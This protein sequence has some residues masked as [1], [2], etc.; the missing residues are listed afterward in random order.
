MVRQQ[1][2]NDKRQEKRAL[3]FLGTIV[4]VL[5]FLW[6]FFAPGQGY[7]HYRKIQREIETLIKENRE[8]EVKNAELAED[9]T[10]LK[11]DDG[12]LEEVAR[13]KHGLLKKN[14]MV[15]EFDPPK[16]KKE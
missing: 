13:K 6:I 15:Y 1:Q 16:K 9:I 8:L 3:W 7:F 14:E 4:A 12:Y 2:Q 5:F 11:S 10:R